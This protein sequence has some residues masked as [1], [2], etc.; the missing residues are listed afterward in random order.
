M[1]DLS[2]SQ[3]NPAK[4]RACARRY[5]RRHHT[6]QSNTCLQVL[7]HLQAEQTVALVVPR[8]ALLLEAPREPH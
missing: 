4:A 5:R 3:R 6:E 7:Q 1:K 2:W 8:A